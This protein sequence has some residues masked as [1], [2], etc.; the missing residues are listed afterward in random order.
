M[1]GNA[2]RPSGNLGVVAKQPS[3]TDSISG[4][5]EH[6]HALANRAEMV[7]DRIFGSPPRDETAETPDPVT[8]EEK[9]HLLERKLKSIENEIERL[10]RI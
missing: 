8:L 5:I 1:E 6:A 9:V 4:M 2:T 3:V 10:E 7:A